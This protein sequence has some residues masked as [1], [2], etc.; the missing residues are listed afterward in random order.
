MILIMSQN[1]RTPMNRF[2]QFILFR[3][4]RYIIGCQSSCKTIILLQKIEITFRNHFLFIYN[5]IILLN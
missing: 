3:I 2:F 1:I 5:F 4:V